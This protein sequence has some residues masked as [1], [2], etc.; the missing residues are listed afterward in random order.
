[1]PRQMH[2][3]YNRPKKNTRQVWVLGIIETAKPWLTHPKR[4]DMILN[5]KQATECIEAGLEI[6]YQPLSSAIAIFKGG[7]ALGVP[8]EVFESMRSAGKIKRIDTWTQGH[9]YFR[10]RVDVY[11]KA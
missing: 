1:M 4:T 9:H 8:T 3:S 11:G 10:G 2:R 7:E 6:H 5:E